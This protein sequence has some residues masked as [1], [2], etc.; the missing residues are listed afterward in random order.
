LFAIRRTFPAC[1]RKIALF[2]VLIGSVLTACIFVYG[3]RTKA[4]GDIES[5]LYTMLRKD[6]YIKHPKLKFEI[7]VKSIQGR[8]LYGVVLTRKAADGGSEIF[9]VADRAELRVDAA[10]KQILVETW[11]CQPATGGLME[12]KIWVADLPADF[13]RP[14]RALR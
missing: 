12:F 8:K 14:I 2:V 1:S 9:A 4:T 3:L 13:D 6:G 5:L 11:M 7:H 10:K